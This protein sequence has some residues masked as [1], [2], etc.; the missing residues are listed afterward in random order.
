MSREGRWERKR[1]I[2]RIGFW[3]GEGIRRRRVKIE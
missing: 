2:G 1:M 3:E